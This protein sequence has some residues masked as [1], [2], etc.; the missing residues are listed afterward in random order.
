MKKEITRAARNVRKKTTEAAKSI[1]KTTTR[2]A[3]NLK[4]KITEMTLDTGDPSTPLN[5]RTK[6]QLYNRARE[7]DISGRSKM[8]KTQLVNAIRR[9]S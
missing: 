6:Q 7:L 2:A 8:T 1:R 9:A 4:E 5:E 3:R